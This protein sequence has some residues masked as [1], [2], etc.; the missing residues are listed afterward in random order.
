MS[1]ISRLFRPRI[2]IT[3][4]T[5]CSITPAGRRTIENESG[6]GPR[7][8]ILVSLQESEKTVRDLARD[9]NMSIDETRQWLERMRGNV[10]FSEVT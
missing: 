4:N 9:V 3:A 1:G 2:R 5:M 6:Y 8:D 10:L 7:F